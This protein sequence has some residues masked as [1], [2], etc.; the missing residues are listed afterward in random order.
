MLQTVCETT[1]RLTG[2][3]FADSKC[4]QHWSAA[5]SVR[6]QWENVESGHCRT[7]GV[8]EEALSESHGNH[9]RW[10]FGKSAHFAASL[11]AL[12]TFDV[13]ITAG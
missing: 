6:N 10:V 1:T 8:K 5:L 4:L 9:L 12:R 2:A 13:P 7:F 11:S 3:T